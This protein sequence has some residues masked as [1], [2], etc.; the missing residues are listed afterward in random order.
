MNRHLHPVQASSHCSCWGGS[1]EDY[2][3]VFWLASQHHSIWRCSGATLSH[4]EVLGRYP[5][6]HSTLQVML[7]LSL[8]MSYPACERTIASELV[9]ACKR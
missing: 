2:L 1:L 5:C 6:L 3:S 7:A 8:M 9:H 4:L